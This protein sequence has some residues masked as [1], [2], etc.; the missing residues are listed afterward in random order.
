MGTGYGYN[1]YAVS[2]ARISEK[3]VDE[4]RDRRALGEHEQHARRKSMMM[5]GRSQNFFLILR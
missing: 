2:E 1:G 4:W 3:N 5:I